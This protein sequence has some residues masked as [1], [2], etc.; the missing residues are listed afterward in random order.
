M[1]QDVEATAALLRASPMQR[2]VARAVYAE[3][4]KRSLLAC[5]AGAEGQEEML[6]AHEAQLRGVAANAPLARLVAAL[7]QLKPAAGV[8]V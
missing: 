7:R 2:A 5:M 6:A 4:Y 8:R 3:E 1:P